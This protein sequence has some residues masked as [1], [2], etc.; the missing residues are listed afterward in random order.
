MFD[1]SSATSI[2]QSTH[3]CSTSRGPF[4]SARSTEENP[5]P[6]D[7]FEGRF[8]QEMFCERKRDQNG[9]GA[10]QEY[11]VCQ[12]G[13]SL[14]DSEDTAISV[15]SPAL[16][17]DMFSQKAESN[18]GASFTSPGNVIQT[19]IFSGGG[20]QLFAGQGTSLFASEENIISGTLGALSQQSQ[21]S[22]A[23]GS[24]LFQ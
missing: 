3:Y 22:V 9:I 17:V 19:N 6:T 15:V 7:G 23:K 2:G 10:L 4:E 16:T 13:K 14:F 12:P 24:D 21:T 8:S 18:T 1:E 20:M 5:S 11:S